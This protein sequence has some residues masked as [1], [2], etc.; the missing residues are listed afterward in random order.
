MT[1]YPAPE[2]IVL[3]P[4]DPADITD[5]QIDFSNVIPNDT[6]S[7]IPTV[8]ITLA[9]TNLTL[10]ITEVQNGKGGTNKSASMRLSG[11][12]S[13]TNYQIKATILTLA[14]DTFARSVIIPV[15]SL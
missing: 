12:V 11:G 3:S 15:E 2:I 14:G 10:I 9:G 5:Y 7:S 4:K 1:T 8:G 6:I 13:G